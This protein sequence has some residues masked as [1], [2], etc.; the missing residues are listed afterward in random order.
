MRLTQTETRQPSLF[1]QPEQASATLYDAA[2]GIYDEVM[3]D[4]GISRDLDQILLRHLDPNHDVRHL[5]IGA[6][7]LVMDAMDVCEG[8]LLDDDHWLIVL[9]KIGARAV[10]SR[11]EWVEFEEREAARKAA[12]VA[13]RHSAPARRKRRR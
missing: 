11:M 12:E 5:D 13:A 8:D 10:M 3:S 2:S 4:L 6:D 7:L 9:A 1:D